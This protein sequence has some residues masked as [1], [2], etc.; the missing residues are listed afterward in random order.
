MSKGQ[1]L[2]KLDGSQSSH[3]HNCYNGVALVAAYTSSGD[4]HAVVLHV[5]SMHVLHMCVSFCAGV[6]AFVIMITFSCIWK[7]EGILT[8]T[9]RPSLL[10]IFLSYRL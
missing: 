3:F 1:S 8:R 6:H 10:F 5:V 2:N 9:R 7:W 4:L